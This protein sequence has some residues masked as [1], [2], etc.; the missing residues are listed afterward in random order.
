MKKMLL[1]LFAGLFTA[2]LLAQNAP[3]KPIF[4]TKNGAIKGYDPVAYFTDGQPVKGQPDI[5]FDWMGARWHFASAEHRDL[6]S[7][8]PEKYAP[9]YGGYC[10]YGWADGYAVKIEPEAWAIVEGKLYLNYDL[11]IQKKWN[12]KQAEY[13]KTADQKWAKAQG[14]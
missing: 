6:F 13:I 3:A 4:S 10:A 12:K 11:A 7:A 5:V 14:H 9:Q 8:S 1:L 2:A